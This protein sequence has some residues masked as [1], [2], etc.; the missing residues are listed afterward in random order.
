[1][2]NVTTL[3]GTETMALGLLETV[4]ILDVNVKFKIKSRTVSSNVITGT[5]PGKKAG[6]A[7]GVDYEKDTDK[8]AFDNHVV[9]NVLLRGAASTGDGDRSERSEF[10]CARELY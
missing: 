6:S 10:Y 8:T 5:G 9:F 7:Q 3:D 4:N 2:S 1:M